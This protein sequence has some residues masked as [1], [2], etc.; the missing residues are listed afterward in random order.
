MGHTQ[1]ATCKVASYTNVA[2][3]CLCNILNNDQLGGINKC[4]GSCGPLV[5]RRGVSSYG[6]VG[7]ATKLRH[8]VY[9]CCQCTC[10]IQD[11]LCVYNAATIAF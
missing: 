4:L 3:N 2:V 7:R 5:I 10:T 9:I 8:M 11:R 1:Q 6:S